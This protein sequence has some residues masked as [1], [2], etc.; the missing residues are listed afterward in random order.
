MRRFI[1]YAPPR[2]LGRLNQ[3]GLNGRRDIA[4]MKEMRNAYKTLVE[5]SERTR[6]L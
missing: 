6:Q 1:I 4:R 3:G 5:K 2:L